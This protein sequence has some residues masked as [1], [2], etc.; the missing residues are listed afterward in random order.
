MLQSIRDRLNSGPVVW[1]IVGLICVPMAFFGIE[2]FRTAG[3][4][5]AEIKVGDEDIREPQIQ[6]AIQRQYQ[7]LRAMFG[8]QFRPEMLDPAVIRRSVVE[9]L[10]DDAL[11]RQYAQAQGYRSSSKAVLDYLQEIPAFQQDGKFSAEAYR[12]ALLRQGL[13]PS[14]FERRVG[15]ALAIEQLRNAVLGSAFISP[16]EA[17]IAQRVRRQQRSISTASFALSGYRDAI[18]PTDEALRAAYQ[19]NEERYRKPERLRLAWVE[20]DAAKL[21]EA[22]DPGDALLRTLYDAEAPTRFSVPETVSARHILFEFGEDKDAARA[23]AEQAMADIAAGTA[24]ET[25]ARE[26]SA[27]SSSA[28]EGGALGQLERGSLAPELEDALFAAPVGTVGGPIET[29]FGWHVYRVD[30]HQRDQVKPF[31]SPDVRSALL[32]LYRERDAQTRFQDLSSQMEQLAFETADSLQPVADALGTVVQESDWFTRSGG[33]GIASSAAVL[34]AAFD[35]N[36]VEAGENSAPLDLGSGRLA[37]I[38]KLAYEPAQLAPFEEVAEQVRAT[39]VDELAL[40]QARADADAAMQKL[41]S[42]TALAQAIADYP[43]ASLGGDKVVGRDDD[44]LAPEVL[45]TAFRLPRPTSAATPS[46]ELVQTPADLVLVVLTQV[47]EPAADARPAESDLSMLR[48][49]RAGAELDAYRMAMQK[50][51]PVQR[52]E[53]TPAAP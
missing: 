20:L 27:D 7:Q 37:V 22:A 31:E 2:S 34:D 4:D 21:P 3:S 41:R 30:E 9:Q 12:S 44:T 6:D 1:V 42:G 8:E 45:A 48:E 25:V 47:V 49:A 36:I 11:L 19:Q 17:S 43:A 18:K 13:T 52:R 24:F 39:L 26:R 40:Q 38:R 16:D 10:V 14:E 53:A 5:V 50:K 23:R 28:A 51:I 15:E 33:P 35:A 46:A 32:T 29:S